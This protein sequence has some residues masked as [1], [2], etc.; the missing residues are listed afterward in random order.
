MMMQAL[1]RRVGKGAGAAFN[2]NEGLSCAVP[3]MSDAT[4]ID[5]AG[6][7]GARESSPRRGAMPA[8]LPTL[9]DQQSL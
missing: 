8:P 5:A 6:G 3:T 4:R 7:H 9:Q 1:T 2:T